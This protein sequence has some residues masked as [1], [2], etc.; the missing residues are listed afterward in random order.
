MFRYSKHE[1]NLALLAMGQIKIGTLHD[2]RNSEHKLGITDADEG[3][4][5][6][7]IEVDD[8]T[9][10]GPPDDPSRK[11]MKDISN[12]LMGGSFNIGDGCRLKGVRLTREIECKNCYILC[13]S[14]KLST[15][16]MAEC[17]DA[18]SCVEIVDIDAFYKVLTETL[19]SIVGA[20]RFRGI[21][22]VIYQP[23]KEEWNGEDLGESPVLVKD[24]SFSKQHEIRAVWEL[25][26][27]RS[28]NPVTLSNFRLG[29]FCKLREL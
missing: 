22:K 28:I 26:S 7:S 23:R 4:K 5:S 20:V 11:K 13:T 21:H 1:H 10:S 16:T 25:L 15:N 24:R 19:N 9:I 2:F 18:D 6:V 8:L 12:N 29:S 27:D 3:K 14:E 17:G